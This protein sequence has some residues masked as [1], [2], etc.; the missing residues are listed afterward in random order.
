MSL[1]LT[2]AFVA[3]GVVAGRLLAGVVRRVTGAARP[4][5]DDK[6]DPK[7][8]DESGDPEDAAGD[9][10][11]TDAPNPPSDGKPKDRKKTARSSRSAE[12]AF[13]SF[14]C[15]LGDVILALGSDEA[16]LAGALLLSEEVPAVA[17]FIAP[18]AGGD[19][20]VLARPRPVEDILWL[21]PI[22]ASSLRLGAEP[23]SSLEHQGERFERLRRLPFR[24]ERHG[25]GA[26][27]VGDAVVLADYKSASG[28]RLIVLVGRDTPRAWVGRELNAGMYDVLASGKDS[29]DE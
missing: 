25:T 18:D 8:D 17:L 1:L 6:K 26:P 20:A 10:S 28:D 9:A 14:P 19:R 21:S 7:D 13:A 12:Q 2:T 23:P 5:Q 22:A 11:S 27:D 4:P 24:A 3:T 29:L 15:Q 16:W